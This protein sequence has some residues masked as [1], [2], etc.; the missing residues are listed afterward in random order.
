MSKIISWGIKFSTTLPS[1]VGKNIYFT[2]DEAK[3][4]NLAKAS[5]TE[6]NFILLLRKL[7]LSV[8][9]IRQIILFLG[10]CDI[11]QIEMFI[12]SHTKTLLVVEHIHIN[13]AGIFTYD[14]INLST[15]DKAM[16]I[17]LAINPQ[18]QKSTQQS[19]NDIPMQQETISHLIN[20]IQLHRKPHF[21]ILEEGG[22]SDSIRTQM[23]T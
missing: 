6:N 4:E 7:D 2:P 16:N 17:V 10:L 12:L 19:V 3:A 15:H 20:A 9:D 23:L 18:P 8:M 11:N 22:C 14:L 21:M 1:V 13:Q 5:V